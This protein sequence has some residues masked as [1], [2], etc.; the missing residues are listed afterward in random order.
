MIIP[1]V[2]VFIYGF[3]MGIFLSKFFKFESSDGDG[4]SFKYGID[5]H[6]VIDFINSLDKNGD[7]IITVDELKN[8]TEYKIHNNDSHN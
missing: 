6:R 7:G 3:F 5:K 2:K 8:S 1:K 4:C